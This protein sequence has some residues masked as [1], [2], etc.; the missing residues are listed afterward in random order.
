MAGERGCGWYVCVTEVL[1]KPQPLSGHI[2]IDPCVCEVTHD[3]LTRRVETAL[4]RDPDG[5][6][7]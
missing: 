2:N 7:T 1:T 3:S 5:G 4:S 6:G